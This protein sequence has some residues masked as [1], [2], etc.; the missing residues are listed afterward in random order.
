MP[1]AQTQADAANKSECE[2]SDGTDEGH[3]CLMPDLSSYDEPKNLKFGPKAFAS[4]RMKHRISVGCTLSSTKSEG[5]DLEA[6]SQS[7]RSDSPKFTA[8]RAK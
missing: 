8:W 7:D 3:L 4:P 1:I 6:D 5:S 2:R